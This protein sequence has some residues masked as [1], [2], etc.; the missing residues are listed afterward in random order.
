MPL[1]G[2]LADAGAWVVVLV[3]AT[4]WAC[5]SGAFFSGRALGKRKLAPTISP[6]KTVEGAAG[7]MVCALAMALGVGW[8]LLRLDIRLAAAVGVLTGVLAPVGDLCESAMKRELGIKDFGSLF[9]GHGGVLD[10]FDSLLFTA[11]VVYYL[12][13][14]VN[15]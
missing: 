11:P 12:L 10:R 2:M 14:M 8:L 9:P 1:P 15:G 6:G 4:T 7:G 13:L 5:D 3:I